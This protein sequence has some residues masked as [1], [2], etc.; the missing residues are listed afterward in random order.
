MESK[1]IVIT[2][3]SSGIGAALARQRA[4][5]GR[6]AGPCRPSPRQA[7][8]RRRGVRQPRAGR[9]G[10]RHGA[11]RR[12]TAARRGARCLR[13]RRCLG[14]QCRAGHQSRR[15]RSDRR[16]TRCDVSRQHQGA[17]LRH[18]GDRPAFQAA[19]RGP[20]HQCVDGAHAR[21]ERD[22]SIGVQRSEGGAQRPHLEPANR[23]ARQPP[24]H[25]GVV[26]SARRRTRRVPGSVARRHA[27]VEPTAERRQAA[28]AG[29]S[30]R[31]HLER[32]RSP[33]RRG[34]F[35]ARAAR[36]RCAAT[37]R[38]STGSSRRWRRPPA[39]RRAAPPA[40]V[41]LT[42]RRPVPRRNASTPAR[43]SSHSRATAHE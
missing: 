6:Y 17:A 14:E 24:S 31:H 11:R 43:Q 35:V 23:P 38:M 4:G 32:D 36:S 15:P 37:A 25:S 2:G 7:R 39:E 18:A 41:G 28:D 27:V 13:P 34:V 30:C 22:V 16:R 33:G 26:D 19:G 3:A 29:R 40:R 5:R 8:C 21:F 9:A 1:V 42:A 20:S 10:R 12:R